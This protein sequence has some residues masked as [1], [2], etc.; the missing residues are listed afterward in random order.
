MDTA[1]KVGSLNFEV[2]S[3]EVQFQATLERPNF[4]WLQNWTRLSASLFDQLKPKGLNLADIRVE[5]AGS[6]ADFQLTASLLRH[7]TI[8]RVKLDSV[9][10]HCY[11]AAG[12]AR[13]QVDDVV[14]SVLEGLRQN[15]S[16]LRVASMTGA[17]ALH[18]LVGGVSDVEFLSTYSRSGD[19]Q[20]G[21][22]SGGGAALYFGECGP[23]TATIVSLDRS[24]QVMGAVFLRLSGAW[25]GSAVKPAELPNLTRDLVDEALAQLH[26]TIT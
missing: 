15:G 6:F 19:V 25:N 13:D 14:V 1:D 3:S 10:V 24:T 21:P 18:G 5:A 22:R 2:R 17:V 23:R 26:L 11:N 16:E 20:L 12:A 4:D 7:S 9:E 8:V